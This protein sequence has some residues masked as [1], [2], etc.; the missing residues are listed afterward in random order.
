[1]KSRVQELVDKSVSAMMS[2]IEIYN[3]PDF[4]YREETFAILAIN[5]WELLLKAK[6]LEVN[7]H[8]IKSLHVI[9]NSKKRK[10]GKPYKHP[11]PKLT[12][13]GNPVTHDFKKLTNKFI[14]QNLISNECYKNLKV[15][16]EIRNSSVHFYNISGAFALQ[17]QEVGS[18]TVKNYVRVAEDWFQVGLSKFNFYLMPL[19]FMSRGDQAVV[20]TLSNEEKNFS[21]YV[22]QLDDAK[23]TLDSVTVSLDISFAR[24]KAPEALKVQITNDP[25]ARKVVLTEEQ[26][27]DKYPFVYKD[28]VGQCRSRYE[29]F[30]QNGK[31][32]N[33]MKSFKEQSKYHHL[34][35]LN[36]DNPRSAR[37]D[38][39]SE[40]I[41][42]ELDKHYDK[43][44]QT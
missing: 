26:V 16:N 3:K 15:L 22:Q 6:W 29:N 13:C 25:S 5:A 32:N 31:F 30:L 20:I 38:F 9:D 33:L 4:K 43:K 42:T 24:S 8:D 12:E 28:L 37:T 27:K 35:L 19:T 11:K 40:A 14:G 17:L 23:N 41:L 10:D 44:H 36:P 18:A 1:M 34:R 21:N 39:Y 7:Q 2:A